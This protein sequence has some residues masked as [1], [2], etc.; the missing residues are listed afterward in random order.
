[1][2]L[3]LHA[4][5]KD[6]SRKDKLNHFHQL[7]WIDSI[8]CRLKSGLRRSTSIEKAE[9]KASVKW[10]KNRWDEVKSGNIQWELWR[11][12]VSLIT[13]SDGKMHEKFRTSL[14]FYRK[15]LT[16]GHC[17]MGGHHDLMTVRRVWALAVQQYRRSPKWS[18]ILRRNQRRCSMIP[19]KLWLSPV[20]SHSQT[21]QCR[22]FC[23]FKWSHLLW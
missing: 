23:R 13:L 19:S 1:M 4:P 17:L 5:T 15:L 20:Q 14:V 12:G 21:L 6:N 8:H 11:K 3:S 2:W 16:S 10:V 22:R 18:L 7:N 9:Y